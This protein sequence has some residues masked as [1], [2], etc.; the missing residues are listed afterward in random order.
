MLEMHINLTELMLI[1]SRRTKHFHKLPKSITF[2]SAQLPFAQS[3]KNFDF[4]FD[5]RITTNEHASIISQ[6]YYFELHRLPS[7]RRF[8]TNTAMAALLSA[9]VLSRIVCSNSLLFR[10][11]HDVTF[12]LQRIQN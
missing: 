2:G 12:R 9:F 3:A 5:C 8:P 7:H 1:A 10:S 11:T 4:T 6:I